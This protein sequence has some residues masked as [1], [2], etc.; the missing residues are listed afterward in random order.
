MN[1]GEKIYYNTDLWHLINTYVKCQNCK[2][3]VKHDRW[4]KLCKE[5]EQKKGIDHI[6]KA[7]AIPIYY[8][9]ND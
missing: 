1:I 5:C 6:A 3:T 7:I 8:Y 2:K 4:E 9:A